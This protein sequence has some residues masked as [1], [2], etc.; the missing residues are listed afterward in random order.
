MSFGRIL[1]PTLVTIAIALLD[2][3]GCS[4]SSAM[5]NVET[6]DGSAD[7]GGTGGATADTMLADTSGSGGPTDAMLADATGGGGTADSMFPSTEDAGAGQPSGEGFSWTVDGSPK[8]AKVTS[9]SVSNGKFLIS[10]SDLGQTVN[11]EL[12]DPQMSLK[13]GEYRCGT[14]GV[15]FRY[16]LT[17][18]AFDT[19]TCSVSLSQ[20]GESKG[21]RVSGT[22][23]ATVT[24]AYMPSKTITVGK[25]DLT[26]P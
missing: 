13:A 6:S 21:A 5:S 22:F 8:I 25:F 11:I 26:F 16:F 9:V 10:G 2:G 15:V 19:M 7:G 24:S 14:S 4:S 17:T 12:P 20:V 23:S 1:R 3:T 18:F